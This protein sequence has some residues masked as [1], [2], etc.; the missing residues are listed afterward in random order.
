MVAALPE[1]VAGL[2]ARWSLTLGPPFEPGGQCS[3]VAPAGRGLVLKVGWTHD[4]AR[5]EAAGL[6]AWNGRGAVRV[7]AE[8]HD[9]GTTALLLE[10]AEPGTLL[11]TLPGPERDVV[12]TG[13]LRRLWIE[14]PA[15]IR[16]LRQMC[17]ARATSAAPRLARLDP[18]L[19]REGPALL[20]TLPRDDAPVTLLATDLHSGNVLAARREPWLMIDPKP[21]AGDPAYDV[22]QYLLDDADRLTADPRG[23]ARHIATLAGLDTGRVAAWLFA[24]CVVEAGER[25]YDTAAVA[26]ALRT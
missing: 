23:F 26:R 11:L 14:P 2:A 4:E 7:V 25:P 20:R 17:D 9:A 19:A 3:W 6:R 13:L 21:Y 8:H 18:G 5:D 12:L 15:G 1:I 10:R 16:P 22:T 24:R